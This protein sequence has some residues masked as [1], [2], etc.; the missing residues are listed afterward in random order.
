[1]KPPLALLIVAAIVAPAP[2][3]AWSRPGHMVAAAIAYDELMR[4][5][6]AAVA[7]MLRLLAAHPDPGPFQVAIDRAEGAERDRRLFLEMARW[8][9]DVRGGPDDHP[10]WHYQLRAVGKGN[11]TA[12][13]GS[14]VA[15]LAL[16]L[17]VARDPRA[18]AADRAVALCW[19]LHVVA[20]LHQPLHSAERV[21]PDWPQG[22]DGGSKVFVRDSV[23]G[24]PV[25]LHWFWDDS[26]SRDGAA[27]AAFA[28]ARDLETRFPRTRFADA[29]SHPVAA[30]DASEHWLAESRALAASVAYRADVPQ[31][32]SAAT[33]QSA[34]PGYAEAVVHVSEQRVTLAGYRLAAL[35]KAMFAV[36]P[37]QSPGN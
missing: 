10:T 7:E 27:A 19:I 34:A 33:A 26:V 35:L 8:P 32:T 15:A 29:L 9:D 5:D 16:N 37:G 17:S 13:K 36:R 4:D 21:A 28:R 30:P 22:D 2:A 1:M 6:P 14:G 12:A 11:A 20:D 23:T 3:S 18:P 31:A 25:S 24:Q